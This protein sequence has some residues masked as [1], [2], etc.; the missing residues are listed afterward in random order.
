MSEPNKTLLHDL[1][2]RPNLNRVL[3]GTRPEVELIL[4]IHPS[5]WNFVVQP[6]AL[7][8][9]VIN[10]VTNSLKYTKHGFISVSLRPAKTLGTIDLTIQDTGMCTDRYHLRISTSAKL[11]TH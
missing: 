11:Y 6:G 5:D 7:R 9:V 4:D 10:L 8:R 3:G 2:L 1:T